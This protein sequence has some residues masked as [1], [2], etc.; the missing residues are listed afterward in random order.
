MSMKKM[1]EYNIK[2]IKVEEVTHNVRRIVVEKPG[3]YRFIPGQATEVSIDKDGWREKKRPFTFTS[4]NEWP[5]LEF[6]IK[7][8]GNRDGVTN[9][10]G[11]LKK[12]DGLIIR[13]VWGAIHYEGEGIFLAGGAGVTPF[14]AILRQLRKEG[15]LEGNVLIFSNKSE[16]DIILRDE[17]Y[18]MSKEGLKVFFTL[19]EEE[20]E[21]Y[22]FGRIDE[23]MLKRL[24]DDF[25]KKFYICGPVRMVGEM[26]HLVKKLG[27]DSD[28]IIV[29]T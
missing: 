2:I 3:G 19:T 5:E 13:D 7:V 6:V 27:A 17:F 22:G 20:N 29:E 21:K 18:E 23:E 10:I 8:Y 24:V 4:L 16:K 12:G 25:S 15:K 1:S 14:I 11:M 9:Q 28:S 26:Q